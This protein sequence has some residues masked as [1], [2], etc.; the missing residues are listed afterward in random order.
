MVL[1]TEVIIKGLIYNQSFSESFKAIRI[2]IPLFSSLILLF[3]GV[4]V[5]IRIVWRILLI[6]VILSTVLSLLGIIFRLPIYQNLESGENI[7]VKSYGRILNSNAAFGVIGM[8]LLVSKDKNW[9]NEGKLVKF[10]SVTS[11]IALLLTFNRTYMAILVLEVIY[12]TR[13][14][15]T[16][17]KAIKALFLT[18]VLVVSV[19]FA[20]LSNDVIKKSVDKR[21][22]SIITGDKTLKSSTIDENREIIFNG[23]SNQLNAGHFWIG[24]PM[25]EP[26][27][28]WPKKWST[29]EDREMRVTDTSF[30][31]FLLRYGVIPLLITIVVFKQLFKKSDH[32]FYKSIFV[33]YLVASLNIDSLLRH[34]TV[35][36]LIIVFIISNFKE[37]L[38]D[39]KSFIH[40]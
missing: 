28:I 25:N 7:L 23:V 19:F 39:D 29:D 16:V 38:S 13:E 4:K 9:Y 22:T 40:S 20:Y 33:F 21:I 8:Y 26:I 14:K 6:V 36:F 15:F 18:S 32:I 5:N 27:F 1:F 2:G 34:N 24:M 12:F 10:A 17:G 35:F 11:V 30:I 31:T 3:Q 37:N